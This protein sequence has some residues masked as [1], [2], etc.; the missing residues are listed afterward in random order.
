M[1]T[2]K[3][4]GLFILFTGLLIGCTNPSPSSQ[5]GLIIITDMLGR[6]VEIPPDV[7]KIVGL[8]A[9]ALRLLVYMDATGMVAGIEEPEKR[10]TSPYM[11][12]HPSL[13]KLP[14][15]GPHMGGDAELIMKAAPD[16]IFITY[17]TP[18]DA[19]ALQQKT[20][21]PVVA[22]ECPEFGTER[23]KLFASFRLAGKILNRQERADSLISYIKNS[24]EDLDKR[25]GSIPVVSRPAVYA[26]GIPYS[27]IHGINSTQP[28]YPP[29][30]F[31]NANNVA[32]K[33]DKR[34]V[35]HV[36][37][38]YIDKEQLMLWDPD[39]LF[40]DESGLELVKRDMK[41]GSALFN[42]LQAVQNNR[43]YTLLPYNNYAINYEL[44]L[45]NAWFAGKILY[46]DNFSDVETAEKT[47]EILCAFLGRGIYDDLMKYS[48]GF[49][50]ID[51][52]EL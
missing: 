11:L 9:G 6:Q 21:R 17:T 14:V 50:Q 3:E 43:I 26:G 7:K 33:I 40:I 25:S 51:K 19:D 28:Y 22:L 5:D 20:G 45:A 23:E 35:S 1:Q 30:L 29:F 15:I 37:G 41:K 31:I 39:I 48:K 16:V 8:R 2:L 46:P 38:T 32:S 24:I 44:V 34:L 18:G 42:N 47:N 52:T 10:S 49:R 27:G 4:T 12:A 13:R 36:K